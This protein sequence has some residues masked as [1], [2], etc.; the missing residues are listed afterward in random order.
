MQPSFTIARKIEVASFAVFTA[1]CACFVYPTLTR[2][3]ICRHRFAVY[4]AT[5]TTANA[6]KAYSSR[7]TLRAAYCHRFAV[8]KATNTTA[9]AAKEP[10]SIQAIA[11]K[12]IN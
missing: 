10:T 11:Y 5:N 7:I 9:N 4:K 8:F 3:A 2:G 12:N 6:A 1:R